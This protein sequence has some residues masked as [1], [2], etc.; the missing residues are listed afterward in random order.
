MVQTEGVVLTAR[1]QPCDSPYPL[2]FVAR[3]E[4]LLVRVINNYTATLDNTIL[5]CTVDLTVCKK[6]KRWSNS[7]LYYEDSLGF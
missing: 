3:Y 7:I 4:N 5:K 6:K 2:P 1:V